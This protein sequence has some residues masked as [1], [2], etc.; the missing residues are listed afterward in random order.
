MSEIRFE[1]VQKM[2]TKLDS[3]NCDVLVKSILKLILD[4]LKQKTE[5]TSNQTEDTVI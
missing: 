5:T 4:Q 1:L 3:G 2:M